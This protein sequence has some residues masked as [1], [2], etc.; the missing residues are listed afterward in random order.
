VPKHKRAYDLWAGFNNF[1]RLL[2]GYYR[3]ARRKSDR[4]SVIA[5]HSRLEEEILTIR[6]EL[7]EGTYQW[8]TYRTFWVTAP[9]L[10]KIESAPFRD[11]VVHQGIAEVIE[12]LF[13]PTFYHHSYACRSGRGTHRAMK[14]VKKWAALR[15]DSSYLQMDVS[16]YF[17]SVNHDILFGMIE[18]RIG[19]P[20]FLALLR[21]LLNSTPTP[22]GIPI[23]NLTSQIFAN[24]YLDTLDQYVKRELKVKH[25]VRYMDDIVLLH[26]DRRQLQRWRS[27]IEQF[28]SEKL[29]LTFHPH[30]VA[31]AKVSG[32]V[33][34]VGYRIFPSEIRLR[35]KSL[36]R[37][38]KGL[39]EKISLSQKVRRLLSYEGHLI[40]TDNHQ[41]LMP[42]LR[43]TAF[44]KEVFIEM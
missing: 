43:Q 3:A 9:K 31:L 2:R 24:L 5:F 16:R 21:S 30:K 17:P 32:G 22:N 15:P 38:R 13:D 36:R 44:S 8:G 39:K 20:R 41:S 34:F 10:R 25:Y 29:R 14:T 37:F 6:D 4:D 35:S 40:H 27:S 11:R 42:G 33:S 1:P 28:A 12:T 18:R 7:E 23:G 26:N 19:D